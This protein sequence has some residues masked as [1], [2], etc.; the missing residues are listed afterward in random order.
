M[1]LR[2]C[3]LGR[4]IQPSGRIRRTKT[5]KQASK[6]PLIHAR[7][8][9]RRYDAGDLVRAIAAL[10]LSPRNSDQY[11]RLEA[12]AHTAASLPFESGKPAIALSRLKALC[13]TYPFGEGWIAAQEDPSTNLFT[14]AFTF[15]GGSFIVFPGLVAEATF[16]LKNVS[17]GLFL[18][19]DAFPE[20]RL[21]ARARRLFSAV[22]ALS[23]QIAKRAGLTRAVQPIPAF[24]K[25]V[26]LPNTHVLKKLKQ[27]V[28]FSISDVTALL[29]QYGA[30][31]SDLE[32]LVTPIG[33]IGLEDYHLEDGGLLPKPIVRVGDDLIVAL[34]GMLLPAAWNEV[35]GMTIDSGS[36]GALS[37]RYSLAVWDS[38]NRSLGLLD[39]DPVF[40]QL[41]KNHILGLREGIFTVDSD[42]LI[43]AALVTD[44][45]DQY[46]AKHPF[47][48][49]PVLDF[50]AKVAE[51]VREIER[52]I[53]G[54]RAAPNELLILLIHQG[55][56][57]S[58]TTPIPEPEFS[59]ILTLTGADLETIST[60]EAGDRMLLWKWA[61]SGVEI[62]RKTEVIVFS[63]LD[64]FNLYKARGYSYY[65]SDKR[66]PDLLHIA[67]DGAL[68]LRCKVAQQ[69][70]FHGVR[71]FNGAFGE[72]AALHDGTVPIYIPTDSIAEG[73]GE[74]VAVL[75]E[76]LPLP[77]WIV[78]GR[79]EDDAHR[80]MHRLYAQFADAIAYWFWQFS[81][82]IRDILTPLAAGHEQILI[83][84][85][86]EPSDLWTKFNH[87]A[88][89]DDPNAVEVIAGSDDTVLSVALRPSMVQW[90][91]APDNRG[92][93]HLMR[94]VL[95]G[96]RDLLPVG[97]HSQ[98]DDSHLAEIL[99]QHAPLGPKKK[100]VLYD[101]VTNP[102]LDPRGLPDARK[103]KLADENM[104]L[105]ELGEQLFDEPVHEDTAIPDC[106]RTATLQRVVGFYYGK[107]Q[108]LVASLNPD[109]LLER[110]IAQHEALLREEA[111]Q[112]L[113][114]TTRLACFTSEAELSES[115]QKEIPE[116]SRAALA[117]RFLI[118]YVAAQPP[119][120][121][122]PFSLSVYDQLKG[123]AMGAID[124][125][126][127]S[128]L[129]HYN[130]ADIKLWILPSGW[131]GADRDEHR[132]AMDT[133][134][135]AFA[136]G[137]IYRSR[138][139]F[140][141]HWSPSEVASGPFP[142]MDRLDPACIAELGFPLTEIL[143]FVRETS[144]IGGFD[145]AVVRL[146]L[147][148]FVETL[149]EKLRWQ[150]EKIMNILDFLSLK[151]RL[152]F[153]RPPPPFRSED[154]Y[155][156]RYNRRYSYIR[157]PLLQR[158]VNAIDE[159]LWG[160]R[161]VFIAWRQLISLLLTGRLPASSSEMRS[162]MGEF[163]SERGELFNDQVADLF[164]RL[165]DVK[166]LRRVKKI[167]GPAGSLRPPGDIDVLIAQAKKRRLLVVECKD[168][169][170]GCAPH[171]LQSELT[172]LFEGE[173]GKPSAIER[174]I[175]R[176]DWV[177]QNLTKVFQW[178]GLNDVGKRWKV[179]SLIIVD[180][181]LV[182]PYLKRVKV[183]IISY[184][185]LEKKIGSNGEI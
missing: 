37:E 112:R 137:E 132:A 94:Q 117:I 110:L 82:T 184:A 107:L 32:P 172:K 144:A 79:Y 122:R 74:Y 69:R 139:S 26:A 155:P 99:N 114:I 111:V 19:A 118:E 123:L 96:I 10:H 33:S 131:I 8:K 119:S 5:A 121:I 51:R 130:L 4:S 41:P 84:L 160:P 115:L 50:E 166:V 120:G 49:W 76:G 150:A 48:S 154:I 141:R 175:R 78:S 102:V 30:A 167:T 6:N 153:L 25:P 106:Q 81:P 145:R 177:R 95:S 21:S 67:T 11:I 65:L 183:P 28:S 168:L 3:C 80:S 71:L 40:F 174:H 70:D 87:Q 75:V 85:W 23:D 104:L 128:D 35:I 61:R 124:F 39:H 176:T 90:L 44:R 91:S 136:S 134:L 163:N 169:A 127:E 179:D 73:R 138:R 140:D 29:Q 58:L 151:R 126:T 113:M 162:L 89:V 59:P 173:G 178:L 147:R 185:E 158:T 100:V 170:V 133:F 42:K 109:G 1:A 64:E 43:Y 148:T 53:L 16:I 56:G 13:N 165:P 92:E 34:P 97:Y 63:A 164:E 45:L 55:I 161:H 143:G 62:R 38:V 57:R 46:D 108:K 22:L 31:L 103:V 98:L 105:D 18:C 15:F 83:R 142:E 116:N 14:E 17:K 60:L 27:A 12:L 72:V 88:P 129:I 156:W 20:P 54:S 47:G 157:R 52:R 68:S 7:D 86:I 180:H 149:S 66:K 36:E 135:P 24:R 2:F 181:E 93:R 182:T 125:G 9:L 101:A 159:V 171:E 152:D 146:Q 77:I